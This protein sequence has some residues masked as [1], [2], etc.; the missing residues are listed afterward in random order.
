MPR[1][2]KPDSE[3]SQKGSG[4]K[5]HHKEQA[6]NAHDLEVFEMSLKLMAPGTLFREAL[7]YILQSKRGTLIVL[8]ASSKVLSKMEGGFELNIPFTPTRLSELAKMDGAIILDEKAERIHFA[9]IF[10]EMGRGVSSNETGARHRAAEKL[11]RG[12]GVA[13]IAVSERKSTLTLYVGSMKRV[14]ET[15]ST[16]MNKANQAISTLEKYL[17]VLEN[18][19]NELGINEFQDVASIRDVCRV[20]QRAEIARRIGEDIEGYG[21]QLGR[22]G[23]LVSLQLFELKSDMAMARLV[24][25]DY[26]KNH[27]P[28]NV[29]ATLQQI[30]AMKYEDLLDMNKTSVAL[31]FYAPEKGIKTYISPRG[32]RILSMTEGMSAPVIENI[33]QRFGTLQ[34]ILRA[35]R[36]ELVAVEGVDDMLAERIEVGLNLV[37]SQLM[38]DRNRVVQKS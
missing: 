33:V 27:R 28:D 6:A 32:Y 25:K 26:I 23:R 38:L 31:G 29:E 19:I 37:R 3:P 5:R 12:A 10:I 15:I 20:I 30:A 35:S 16:I 24:V 36:E 22:E 11:A 21:V 8:G 17:S 7:S 13:V 2:R 14:L 18:A 1:A 4:R 34:N 9:N